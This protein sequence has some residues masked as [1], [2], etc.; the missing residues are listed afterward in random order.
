M[1]MWDKR[2][3]RKKNA[4]P[5]SVSGYKLD[6]LED[7]ILYNVH[8]AC[9][10]GK[11]TMIPIPPKENQYEHAVVLHRVYGMT[12]NEVVVKTGWNIKDE[13]SEE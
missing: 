2:K 7:A 4:R 12:V 9:A 1:G 6:S 11:N 10:C 3:K 8:L 13:D 5:I